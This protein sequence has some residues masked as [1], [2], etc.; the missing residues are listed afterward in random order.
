MKLAFALACLPLAVWPAAA[1]PAPPTIQ[2]APLLQQDLGGQPGRELRMFDVGWPPGAVL[3]PHMHPGEEF[4]TVL[5]GTV[6]V[7]QTGGEWRTVRPGEAYHNAEGVPHE[8][9]NPG[10]QPARSINVFVLEKGKPLVQP[11]R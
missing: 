10:P 6:D 1:Q 3:M 11:V 7:R 5:D 2:I 4:A 9:R 8:A